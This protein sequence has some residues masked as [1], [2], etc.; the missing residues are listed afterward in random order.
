MSSEMNATIADIL[1]E[2][3]EKAAEADG[4]LVAVKEGV[5]IGKYANCFAVV[6]VNLGGYSFRIHAD[7]TG[8]R[9]HI[10]IRDQK[11]V[12]NRI[13]DELVDCINKGVAALAAL[14]EPPSN[15]AA[16][17]EAQ[18][19]YFRTRAPSALCAAKQAERAVDA[20]LAGNH[21]QD[22]NQPRQG[23]LL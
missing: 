21:E 5:Y 20:L 1:R 10:K 22:N 9:P 19:E 14:P 16:M 8:F 11:D 4:K 6:N 23:T 17:R 2:M 13:M 3:R 7:Q 15:A 18:R 12:L